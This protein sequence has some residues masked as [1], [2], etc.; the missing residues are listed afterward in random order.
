MLEFEVKTPAAGASKIKRPWQGTIFGMLGIGAFVSLLPFWA[1][2]I[3]NAVQLFGD[4][5]KGKLLNEGSLLGAALAFFVFPVFMSIGF[6]RGQRWQ[7]Y[8]MAITIGVIVVLAI[9]ANFRSLLN[10]IPYIVLLIPFGYL[11]FACLDHPFY[12]KKK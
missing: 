9:F 10:L 12:A 2:G 4:I 5:I 11:L 6:L 3:L 8:V 1:V 7:L